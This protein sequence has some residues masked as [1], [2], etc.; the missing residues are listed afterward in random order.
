MTQQPGEHPDRQLAF[1]QELL[2]Q[3][4]AISG[5]GGAV[6]AHTW[7]IHGSISVDGEV[8]MA[9]YDNP[10]QARLVLG[11]L[12]AVDEEETT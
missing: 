10:N 1:L 8:I 7:A 2:A 4:A 11:E 9:D 5:D 3:R 6:G 12:S